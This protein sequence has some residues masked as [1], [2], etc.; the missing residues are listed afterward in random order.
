[1][2]KNEKPTLYFEHHCYENVGLVTLWFYDNFD[3]EGPD[4]VDDPDAV[5]LVGPSSIGEC[6]TVGKAIK[7]VL[8]RLGREVAEEHGADD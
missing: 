7:L 6:M 4:P 2:A 5:R 1:M 8:W 3:P